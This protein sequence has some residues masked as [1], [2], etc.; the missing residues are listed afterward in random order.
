MEYQQNISQADLAIV[1][2]HAKS[3][4]IRGLEPMASDILDAIPRLNRGQIE[5]IYPADPL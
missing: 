3:N 2:L 4:A 1:V 5:H